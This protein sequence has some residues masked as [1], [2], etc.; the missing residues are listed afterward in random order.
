MPS[1]KELAGGEAQRVAPKTTEPSRIMHRFADKEEEIQVEMKN[2]EEAF[3]AVMA[4]LEKSSDLAP[5]AIGH[6]LVHGGDIFSAPELIDED[7]LKTLD[8]IN[9]LA[10]LHNPPAVKLM[11]ACLAERPEI[12]Q[13]A[14]FDTAYHASMPKYASAYPISKKI[15]AR[16]SV[17]KYGFHGTSHQFVVEE[18]CRLLG[19]PLDKFTAVSCHLGSGGASL[20]AVK[21]GKSVDNTM[22][23]SPLQGL[24]MSTR[25]GDLDPSIVMRLLLEKGADAD[26]VEK[27]LNKE[28]GVLGLSGISSD[29]RDVLSSIKNNP[30]GEGFALLK[31][32]AD[33]Y[34]WRTRKYLGS[35]LAALGG[36]DAVIFTD[37]IGESVPSVRWSLC[38]GMDIFGIVPD[39]DLNFG[40]GK[41]P[42]DFSSPKSAVKLLAV[43]TNEE[44]AIA[45]K[46]FELMNSLGMPSRSVRKERSK[47]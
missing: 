9:G 15:S 37:T 26:S 46:T 18:S 11:K 31:Q 19:I 30:H 42:L 6:R 41:L 21:N 47:K 39:H 20:C 16:F 3:L 10:P 5:D 36:A 14:V 27:I 33:I 43:A 34:L 44:I 8:S 7:V 13:I 1:G 45:K 12:P 4:L 38:A 32:A 23:F 2:H 28:S 40:D 29:I 17:R 22:G 24:V 25:C 35:Y